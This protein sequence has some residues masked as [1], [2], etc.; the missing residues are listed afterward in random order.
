MH[1]AVF[2]VGLLVFLSLYSFFPSPQSGNP[3]E[4][5]EV[6]WLNSPQLSLSSMKNEV[7]LVY[8]F[9]PTCSQCMDALRFAQKMHDSYSRQG[10]V[11]VGLDS[12]LYYFENEQLATETL[13]KEKIS[14][15]VAFD[16]GKVSFKSYGSWWPRF[17]LFKK[18]ELVYNDTRRDLGLAEQN[19]RKALGLNYSSYEKYSG[20]TELYAGYSFASVP[21][22]N[23]EGFQGGQVVSYAAMPSIA[24]QRIT[25]D[26]VWLN[27]IDSMRANAQ[28][29]AGV[30]FI[31]SEFYLVAFSPS[32]PVHV[33]ADGFP[34]KPEEAGEDVYFD[35]GYSVL[36][37]SKPGR[38]HAASL[39]EGSHSIYFEV[40]S[41]FTLYS[42]SFK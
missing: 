21:L 22:G 33:F 18:G 10:L 27:S 9:S 29:R 2:A 16:S 38:Y 26:G 11:V 40:P 31:G 34:L 39:K 4:F 19:V 13:K 7:V 17:Y 36:N 42:M 23:P 8:F 41:G 30:A 28:A 24:F 3:Y 32:S 5:R 35:A 6:K 1:Y 14:H 37:V 12:P 15:P 20:S 25:L